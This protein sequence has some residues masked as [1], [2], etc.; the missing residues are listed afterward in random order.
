MLSDIYAGG[1][2]W[3]RG[4][5]DVEGA[6]KAPLLTENT[7]V[8]EA[9][10]V[11]EQNSTAHQ[12]L[13]RKGTVEVISTRRDRIFQRISEVCV[14]L[15]RFLFYVVQTPL[16]FILRLTVPPMIRPEDRWT[17][18]T[19]IVFSITP[20]TVPIFILF[21]VGHLNTALFGW[22]PL[23]CVRFYRICLRQQN[24]F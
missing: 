11:D 23:W 13:D 7:E 1:G 10:D 2:N 3:G 18:G 14:Q 4:K 5:K 17:K 9:T 12:P 19:R 8:Y 20:I 16:Q 24:P 21:C 6:A 15:A 22:C